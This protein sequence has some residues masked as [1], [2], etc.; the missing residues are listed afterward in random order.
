M[1]QVV[2]A[3]LGSAM[4][5]AVMGVIDGTTSVEEAFT[6]MF[7]NIAEAFIN[8]ATQMI[9]KALIMK[10]LNILAPGAGDAGAA[11]VPV[12]P[13][14][15]GHRAEGGPV[16]GDTPYIVGE[17]GPELFVPSGAGT[18]INNADS[19]A[20]LDRYTP[21]S[22]YNYSPNLSITTGPVMQMNNDEYIR[23]EDFER[24]LRQASEDGAKRGEAI[25]LR[26]LKNSRS[27]RSTLGM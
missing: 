13:P 9:A 26:R 24:G 5:S 1:A 10:A 27:T 25:T 19:R 7:K 8:M 11:A 16:G 2:E 17:R 20:A 6:T 3:E 4:S 18:V 21:N 22:S 14:I 15:L 23:R 12:L